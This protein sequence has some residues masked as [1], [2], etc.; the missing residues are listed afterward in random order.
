M[1]RLAPSTAS[2]PPYPQSLRA[3]TTL[4]DMSR[5][6]TPLR[7]RTQYQT[8]CRQCRTTHSTPCFWPVFHWA[9]CL[10]LRS[11]PSSR[12][13]SQPGVDD[14]GP[15]MTAVRPSMLG[16]T[17]YG[18]RKRDEGGLRKAAVDLWFAVQRMGRRGQGPPPPLP[19]PPYDDPRDG[20]DFSQSGVPRR[21][22]PSSGTASAAVSEPS[23]D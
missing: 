18:K 14:T 12:P 4:A 17:T 7:H 20:D 5:C 11:A 3:G 19:K 16:V 1:G 15:A 6:P 2:W 9:P 21:P 8:L 22:T 10:W 23:E 13:H